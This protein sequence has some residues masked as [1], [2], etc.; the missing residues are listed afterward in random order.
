MHVFQRLPPRSG[1]YGQRD[2]TTRKRD[3]PRSDEVPAKLCCGNA[4]Y[5][6]VRC[7]ILLTLMYGTFAAVRTAQCETLPFQSLAA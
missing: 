1:L 7:Y 6:H 2:E 3:A 4:G 5:C